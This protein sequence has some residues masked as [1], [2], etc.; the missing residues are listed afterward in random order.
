MHSTFENWWHMKCIV[1]RSHDMFWNMAFPHE[2][3]RTGV[4]PPNKEDREFARMC[5]QILIL[6]IKN[7]SP[8]C[9]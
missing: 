7:E 5:E 4:V 8:Q 3:H 9:L 6:S 1:L 2:E